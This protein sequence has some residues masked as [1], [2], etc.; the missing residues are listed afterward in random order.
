MVL[1]ILTADGIRDEISCPFC[2]SDNFSPVTGPVADL[3][4]VKIERKLFYR[5]VL[6]N[7][8]SPYKNQTLLQTQKYA[9]MFFKDANVKKYL[10]DYTNTK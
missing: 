7:F 9:T 8:L 3:T 10:K 2:A 4:G 6:G 5:S 1:P